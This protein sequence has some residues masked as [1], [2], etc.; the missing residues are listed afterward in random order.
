MIENRANVKKA[1]KPEGDGG[2]SI[3]IAFC[4]YNRGA[5]TAMWIKRPVVVCYFRF[6]SCLRPNPA[7][8]SS[9]V[10]SSSM[11]AGSGTGAVWPG[12]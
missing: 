10:P 9:P 11:V 3:P 5:V 7:S 12:A 6:L 1:Q 8:P 2:S 4:I